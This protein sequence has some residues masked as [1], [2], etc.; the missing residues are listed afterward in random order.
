MTDLI[1]LKQAVQERGRPNAT[2]RLIDPLQ[3][4]GKQIPARRWL[5]EGL[6]PLHNVTMLSGDG[7]LG[8]SLLTQQL[9]TACAAGK[10]WLGRQTLSCRALGVYCEDDA[11][12]L[13]RRQA[14]INRSFGIEFSD[15]EDLTLLSRVGLDNSVM[16]WDKP[17]ESG[18]ITDFFRAIKRECQER[19]VQLLILDS[20]HD[21]FGGDENKRP[22][23]RQFINSLRDIA[24]SIDG[25]VILN[26]HPSLSGLNTGTGSAGSTAW[27]NAV[28]SRLFLTRP[29]DDEDKDLRVLSTMKANYGKTG[30][31]IRLKW[32]E[33]VFVSEHLGTPLAESLRGQGAERVFLVLLAAVEQEGRPV[34][35]SRNAGNFVAKVFSL[36]AARQGY[37]KK[38]FE[39][40]MER[41]FADGK[42]RQVSYGRRGD[43]RMR[44][45][46]VREGK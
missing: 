26:A 12:E 33:G 23:A 30:G 29:K 45:E 13:W 4:H 19:G 34:S 37:S 40:A 1:P 11:D 43:N 7:G 20:L 39:K 22:H 14:D 3:W 15:L 9:A 18:K 5:V 46:I 25:A 16:N 35:A 10:E 8:K 21:L 36:H 44:I 24:V 42:I 32:S 6:V 27:N 31:Q 38:D 2:L 41:L 17:W 28:R